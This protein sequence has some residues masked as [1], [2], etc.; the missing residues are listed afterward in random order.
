MTETSPAVLT[1]DREDAV[2][3]AGSLG[4]PV[5]DTEVRIVPSRRVQMPR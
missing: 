5:L 4:K 1:L 3:K 2:R